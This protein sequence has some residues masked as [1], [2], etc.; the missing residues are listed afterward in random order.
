M[1]RKGWNLSR[2]PYSNTIWIV[3]TVCSG[4]VILKASGRAF[5][6]RSTPLL[7]IAGTGSSSRRR[8][9]AP[10]GCRT[11]LP[12][13]PGCRTEPCARLSTK[14][15]ARMW[16]SVAPTSRPPS[17]SARAATPVWAG[18]VRDDLWEQGTKHVAPSRPD[19]SVRATSTL[20]WPQSGTRR[21]RGGT[22]RLRPC[23]LAG[24]PAPDYRPHCG[25]QGPGRPPATQTRRR[26]G[27]AK[28]RHIG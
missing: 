7:P 8:R 21:C 1:L 16:I 2:E 22:G 15:A 24:N 17:S 5:F 28:H 27:D 19:I 23:L 14:T 4:R 25:S 20:T 9:V 11:G 26:P 6:A 10:P 12:H 18:C 13:P 3:P